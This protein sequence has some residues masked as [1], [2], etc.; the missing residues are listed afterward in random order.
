[1]ANEL[2]PIG[3]GDW[4]ARR[5]AHLLSRAGFGGAPEDVA[6]MILY[7]ASDES[8]FVTGAELVIDNAVTIRAF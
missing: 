7:L 8:R 6:S 2:L 5:A 1:M 3:P 4:N